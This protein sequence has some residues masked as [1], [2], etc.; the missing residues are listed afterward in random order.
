MRAFGI[1]LTLAMLSLTL[2]ASGALAAGS[3]EREVPR[4]QPT[5]LPS[6]E[7]EYNRGIAAK[8][9]KNWQAAAGSFQK[10]VS[11]KPAFPEAWNELGFALRN[12]GNYPDS[13]KAYDEALRLKPN[14]P[15]ALEYLGEAYVKLGRVDDA[16]KILERLKPLDAGRATELAEAIDKGK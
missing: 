5:S 3:G 11:L 7:Q 6:A 10:A 9:A 16:R 8:N 13:L 4:A 15:E 14:F 12:Q 2:T 1:L